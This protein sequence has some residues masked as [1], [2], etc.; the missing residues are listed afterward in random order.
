ME[1]LAQLW[2]VLAIAI[3][4]LST[5]IIAKYKLSGKIT[6]LGD[7]VDELGSEIIDVYNVITNALKPDE[8]GIVRLTTEEVEAIKEEI[9]DIIGV[10]KDEE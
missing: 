10:I 3:S 5:Y 8:D 9:D 7:E 4:A 2:P 1:T 6:D